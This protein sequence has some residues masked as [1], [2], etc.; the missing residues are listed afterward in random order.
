[1]QS[2][3]QLATG[4]FYYKTGET[5]DGQYK[6]IGLPPAAPTEPVKKG[7]K[8]KE[9]EV[10][11]QPMEHPKPVRHGVGGCEPEPDCAAA[12]AYTSNHDQARLTQ[13]RH[14]LAL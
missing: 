4:K 14:K 9:E 7:G 10:S 5:Y 11:A 3:D 1:M 8:K 13:S 2:S 6:M 12:T